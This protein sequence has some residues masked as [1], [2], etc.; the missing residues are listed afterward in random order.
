MIYIIMGIIIYL[1][2]CWCFWAICAAGGG[3]GAAAQKAQERYDAEV[4]KRVPQALGAQAREQV[5]EQL[6]VQQSRHR[7]QEL[8]S[9]ESS[10][11]HASIR[12]TRFSKRHRRHC[13]SCGFLAHQQQ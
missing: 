2:L 4:V 5:R 11:H 12:R 6:Q 1:I 3:N 10:W 9:R 13:A 7:S 8:L